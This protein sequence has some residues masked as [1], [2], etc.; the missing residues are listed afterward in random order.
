MEV[1]DSAADL[2]IA[3]GAGGL[4]VLALLLLGAL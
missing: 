2:S 4:P 1:L 3:A